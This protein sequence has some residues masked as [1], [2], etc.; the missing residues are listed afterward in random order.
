MTPEE[1]ADWRRDPRGFSIRQS[2]RLRNQRQRDSD[3]L[4]GN[5]YLLKDRAI[6][7]PIPSSVPRVVFRVGKQHRGLYDF[8]YTLEMVE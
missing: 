5:R 2:D 4:R 3:N 7:D 1:Y 6:D 8:D